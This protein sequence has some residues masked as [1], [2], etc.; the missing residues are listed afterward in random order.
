MKKMKNEKKDNPGV[1][2]PPPLIFLSGLLLGGIVQWFYPL[3]IFPPEYLFVAR[4]SGVLLIIFGLGI[5][6]AAKMKM[7]KANTNIEPWKPT[8]AIISDGIYS[9]SRNPIYVAMVLIYLGVTFVFNA[10]W[11]L[12]FLILVLMAMQ[13]G[14]ILREERYL[15]EKFGKNYSDYKKKVRRWI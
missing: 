2:A 6:F 11:F 5:I 1:I 7:Q 9:Y 15:Q 13:Y 4:S 3:Y 10:V 8:N 12:P 14:V